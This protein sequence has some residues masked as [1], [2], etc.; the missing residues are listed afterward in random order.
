MGVPAAAQWHNS[1]CYRGTGLI[2]A[3]R[4]GLKDTALLQLRYRVQLVAWIQSLAGKL[5][6]ALGAAI[7]NKTKQK[8][9]AQWHTSP[10][11]PGFTVTYATT[12]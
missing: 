5:P 11:L 1:G 9:L 3:R 6:Y 7:K 4:S 2:P 8:T 10:P 12:T